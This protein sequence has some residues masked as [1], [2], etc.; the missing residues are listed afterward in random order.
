MVVDVKRRK[1][2]IT[3]ITIS[4][5]T[6]LELYKLKRKLKKRSFDRLLR[7]LINVYYTSRRGRRRDPANAG[8]SR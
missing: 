6:H 3:T 2:D 4:R 7:Y 1:R 8:G 5:N